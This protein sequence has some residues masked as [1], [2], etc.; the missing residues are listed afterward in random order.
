MNFINFLFGCAVLG[1]A[2]L[3]PLY[4]QQ[5]YGLPA[6][7]AGTLLSARGGRHDRAPRYWPSRCCAAPATGG[8]CWPGS[9]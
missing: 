6:L 4:A 7:A 8:R 3:V 2:A 5:R 9:R 1:F